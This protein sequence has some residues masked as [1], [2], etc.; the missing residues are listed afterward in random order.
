M[1]AVRAHIKAHSSSPHILL[2]NNLINI[3]QN[4]P[5]K[6]TPNVKQRFGPL[7]SSFP[8]LGK[9]PSPF[10]TFKKQPTVEEL[11]DMLL[12]EIKRSSEDDEPSFVPPPFCGDEGIVMSG[13]DAATELV[14][15]L[16]DPTFKSKGFIP[17]LECPV[18]D[19]MAAKTREKAAGY[20]EETPM[21][22]SVFPCDTLIPLQHHNETMS[23]STLLLGSILW[24]IWPPT[25]RNLTLLHR[26]Y[27]EFA[28]DPDEEKFN[29][30]NEL[31]G[32]VVFVQTASEGLRV[33]PYCIMLGLATENSVLAKYSL[34]SATQFTAML[35]KLPFLESWWKTEAHGKEKRADFALA[36]LPRIKRILAGDFDPYPPAEFLLTGQ[37][38]GALFELVKGWEQVNS[39]IASLVDGETAKGIKEV[40]VDFLCKVVGRNCAL[41]TGYLQDKRKEMLAHF[42]DVH[43]PKEKVGETSEPM[44]GVEMTGGDVTKSD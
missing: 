11:Q 34:L 25:E 23:Y 18:L 16:G 20:M 24:M 42:Q 30:A 31:T 14:Q 2:F 4:G 38:G 21:M 27:D 43:W 8:L 35:H 17:N 37:K 33:P 6:C 3:N 36:L 1:T 9:K 22:C 29:I 40:W 19:E 7:E 41:C 28:I 13:E 32:G 5:L 10:A 26:A 12:T 39:S 44:E 15:N